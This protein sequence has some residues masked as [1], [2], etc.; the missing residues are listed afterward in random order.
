[1]CPTPKREMK[2]KRPRGK[3]PKKKG[4]WIG[5]RG[6]KTTQWQDRERARESRRQRARGLGCVLL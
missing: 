5:P 3:E 2:G 4:E 6:L 1:M